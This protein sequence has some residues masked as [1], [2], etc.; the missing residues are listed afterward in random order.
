MF[1]DSR[2]SSEKPAIRTSAKTAVYTEN[3]AKDHA[4]AAAAPAHA[5][6]S[7]GC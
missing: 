7:A 6:D 2:S 3:A 5:I 1:A 4:T